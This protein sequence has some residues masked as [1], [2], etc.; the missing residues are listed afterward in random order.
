MVTLECAT[1]VFE[2]YPIIAL[3]VEAQLGC[4][5]DLSSQNGNFI[6]CNIT[7]ISS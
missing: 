6:P 5:L 4:V 2:G 7:S 3:V 1:S